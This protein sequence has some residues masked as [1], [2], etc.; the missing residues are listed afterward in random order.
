[1]DCYRSVSGRI[2]PCYVQGFL[3][4][5]FSKSSSIKINNALEDHL[6]R[7]NIFSDGK[8]EELF[9]DEPDAPEKNDGLEK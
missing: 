8:F 2:K 3:I 1:M 6:R 7:L 9:F 5:D 4:F